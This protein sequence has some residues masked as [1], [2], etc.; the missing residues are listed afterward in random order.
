MRICLACYGPRVAT[1]LEGATELRFACTGPDGEQTAETM[2]LSASVRDLGLPRLLDMLTTANVD[3][4]ICGALSCRER[5]FLRAQR[6]EVEAWVGGFYRDVIQAWGRG[7]IATKRL[8]GC[9]MSKTDTPVS[10]PR[11]S[12]QA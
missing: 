2:R 11:T 7:Q 8:P 3:L 1:L 6:L 10:T 9:P 4:L 5:D 12:R